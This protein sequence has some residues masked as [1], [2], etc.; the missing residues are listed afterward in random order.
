MTGNPRPPQYLS[1]HAKLTATKLACEAQ[2]TM[3]AVR[4]M[5]EMYGKSCVYNNTFHFDIAKTL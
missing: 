1:K 3:A 2:E 5:M 4:K